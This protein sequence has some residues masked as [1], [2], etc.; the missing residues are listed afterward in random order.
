MSRGSKLSI[1]G[2]YNYNSDIFSGLSVPDGIDRSNVIN[3]ILMQCGELE[4]IYPTYNL[5]KMAINNWSKIEAPI[6]E[7]LY[8][9]ENLEYNPIWNVDGDVID[10]IDRSG[11]NTTTGNNQNINSVKGYNN[12]SW[13]EN[14]KDDGKSSGTG[15]WSDSEKHTTRRTGNIG[16]T[17]TQAMIR[18]EREVA[19][20]ST[21]KYIVN[22]FKKRFCIMIY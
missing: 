15:K 2:L 13:L 8:K 22:S 16:V 11:D 19:D 6:W 14:N 17:T 3:E 10:I 12:S 18:E 1:I 5:M 7:K 21:I 4:L 9:T 20:F